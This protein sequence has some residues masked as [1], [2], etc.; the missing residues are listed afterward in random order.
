MNDITM[1]GEEMMP[2]T[3]ETYSTIRVEAL[4]NELLRLRDVVCE[5]DQKSIDAVLNDE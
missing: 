4:R 2:L 3:E 5:E 1:E